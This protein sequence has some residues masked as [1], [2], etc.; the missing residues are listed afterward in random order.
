MERLAGR[1]GVRRC[2]ARDD[3]VVHLVTPLGSGRKDAA[4][5]SFDASRDFARWYRTRQATAEQPST[6]AASAR[7]NP[8][9]A[10]S[11]RTS[12][13]RSF[14]A[15]NAAASAPSPTG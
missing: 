3:V 5:A 14:R 12:R 2:E 7:D 1:H 6:V 4:A 15:L 10:T 11:R 9:H 13:S 8:S